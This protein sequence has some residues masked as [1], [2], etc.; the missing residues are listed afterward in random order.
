MVL[1]YLLT[2]LLYL[3]ITLEYRNYDLRLTSNT[4]VTEAVILYLSQY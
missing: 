3:L 4:E 2:Y 1:G